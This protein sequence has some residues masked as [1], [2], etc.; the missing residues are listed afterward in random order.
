M[1]EVTLSDAVYGAVAYSDIFSYPLTIDELLYFLPWH[2]GITR[3]E[4]LRS[5][6]TLGLT[7]H[8]GFVTLVK[9]SNFVPLRRKRDKEANT[10]WNIVHSMVW[11]FR[12]IPTIRLVAVTGA[13]SM[14]NV[15][16]DDD[17]D[18]LIVTEGKSVWVTRF[19]LTLIFDV[20]GIRRKPHDRIVSNLFCLN[21]YLSVDALEIPFPKRNLYIAHELAQMIPVFDRNHTYNLFCRKNLWVKRVLPNVWKNNQRKKIM[22]HERF[23][24]LHEILKQSIFFCIRFIDLFFM[25]FQRIYMNSRRTREIVERESIQFHPVDANDWVYKKLAIRLRR[26]RIPLDKIFFTR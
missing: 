16:K 21:M 2:A 20:L 6:K 17:I 5:I 19:L 9:K 13:L 1:H 8:D 14:N 18:L 25:Y 7:Y 3:L 12:Y 26:K 24:F 15:N 4:V 22:H 23:N 10:K 11:I